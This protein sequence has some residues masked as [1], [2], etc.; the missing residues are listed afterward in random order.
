[1]LLNVL[2]LVDR[3]LLSLSFFWYYEPFV[4]M[5]CDI[6]VTYFSSRFFVFFSRP[7]CSS[8][9]GNPMSHS[10]FL[11]ARSRTHPLETD[12]LERMYRIIAKN[13]NVTQ[14]EAVALAMQ[15]AGEDIV[16]NVRVKTPTASGEYTTPKAAAAKI[17]PKTLKQAED[18]LKK[19]SKGKKK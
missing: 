5:N 6:F 16:S 12:R 8:K 9:K 13:F 10:E 2:G 7:Q 18:L 11:E 17:D 14:E 4:F 3:H 15:D 19:L 1:M